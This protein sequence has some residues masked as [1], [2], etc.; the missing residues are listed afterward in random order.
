MFSPKQ[1]GG[2]SRVEWHAGN[3]ELF[4][5]E[6]GDRQARGRGGGGKNTKIVRQENVRHD[7]PRSP[8][9][10]NM[11]LITMDHGRHPYHGVPSTNHQHH[12]RAA[13]S[14]MGY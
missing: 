11:K 9:A 6:D 1:K 8:T 5:S 4:R 10:N 7:D 12:K 3:T 14:L 13:I 2:D